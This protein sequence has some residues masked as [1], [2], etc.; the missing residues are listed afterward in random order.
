MVLKGILL[1]L[2][3]QLGDAAPAATKS[4]IPNGSGELHIT[5][6]RNAAAGFAITSW[7]TH[8]DTVKQHCA[9]LPEPAAER[10]RTALAGWLERNGAYADAAFTYMS[11]TAGML[12]AQHGDAAG[13]KFLDD[14]KEEAASATRQAQAVYFPEAVVTERGCLRLAAALASGLLDFEG[15]AEFFPLLQELKA[16]ADAAPATR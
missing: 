5:E 8:V 11:R 4:A 14:R 10:S 16:E 13:Q 15:Q 1:A 3:S 2:A 9:R 6:P 12:A 7:M